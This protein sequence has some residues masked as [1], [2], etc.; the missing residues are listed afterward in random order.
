[1]NLAK[2]VEVVFEMWRIWTQWQGLLSSWYFKTEN[3]DSSNNAE[4]VEAELFWC[5]CVI[6]VRKLLYC[7]W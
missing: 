6:K 3:A 1:M 5:L 7:K 4:L 2:I